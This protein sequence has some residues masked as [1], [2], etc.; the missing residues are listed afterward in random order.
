[1]LLRHSLQFA[2]RANEGRRV[3]PCPLAITS[4]RTSSTTHFAVCGF[5]IDDGNLRG[6]TIAAPHVIHST[7][8]RDRAASVLSWSIYSR[9]SFRLLG[10]E[11]HSRCRSNFDLPRQLAVPRP[12]SLP[13]AKLTA[14]EAVGR[15]LLLRSMLAAAIARRDLRSHRTGYK[16]VRPTEQFR[17]WPAGMATLLRRTTRRWSIERRILCDNAQPTSVRPFKSGSYKNRVKRR[18]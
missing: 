8:N 18:G 10:S 7:R 11:S 16:S 15:A 12:A 3:F 13:L 9:P 1:M 5:A 4:K 14:I 2:A 17:S 6:V